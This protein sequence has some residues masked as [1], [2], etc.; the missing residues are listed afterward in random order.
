M[1]T[2]YLVLLYVLMK[3][4]QDPVVDEWCYNGLARAMGSKGEK[5]CLCIDV[6]VGRRSDGGVTRHDHDVRLNQLT[7]WTLLAS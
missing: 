2:K 7:V 1:N 4:R 5:Y 6:D 3:H